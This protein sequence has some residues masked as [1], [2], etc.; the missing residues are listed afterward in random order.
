VTTTYPATTT[1]EPEEFEWAPDPARHD[2]FVAPAA[3]ALLA[4]VAPR[5]RVVID[6]VV[7]DVQVCAWVGGPALEATVDDGTGR[8]VL[9]FLG[10]RAVAGVEPGRHL[11]AAGTVSRHTDRTVVLNPAVWLRPCAEEEPP[12]RTSSSS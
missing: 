7:R 3:T 9:V 8:V 12:W 10:R 2:P 6:V 11:V 4:Q 5:D 1:W